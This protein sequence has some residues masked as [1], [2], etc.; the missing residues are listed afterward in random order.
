[1]RA[2]G[3][4]PR[5]V[6]IVGEAPSRT[7]ARPFDGQSGRRLERLGVDLDG[8]A[9]YNVLDEWP[10]PA[11][12][13]SRFR[14]PDARPAA[15]ALL[16]RLSS[17]ARVVVAGHRAAAALGFRERYLVWAPGPTGALWAVLPHPSGVNRWWND[18][19]N[20]D[21]ARRFLAKLR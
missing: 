5:R 17:H 1:V 6:A 16:E 19:E 15:A 18:P 2:P 3:L 21:A 9:L 12:K 10:G 8:V 14:V 11:H 7:S 4:S 13:G 20:A